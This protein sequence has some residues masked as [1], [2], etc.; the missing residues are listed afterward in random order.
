MR[1]FYTVNFNAR[2]CTMKI[3]V[4]GVPLLNMEVE[5]QCSS[6]YPFNNL[7]LESGWVTIRYEAFPLKGTVQLHDEAYLSGEVEMYDMDSPVEPLSK[8]ASYETPTQEKVVVPYIVHEEVFHVDVPYTLVGWRQSMKLDR[9]EDD[10]RPMVF[11]KYNSIISMMRNRSFAQYEEAF[12]ERENIM[13]VC[14]NISDEEKR[15][16]MKAVEEAIMSCSEIVPLSS[17]D[18]IELAAD[19]RLVR[20]VK[21]DGESALRLKND[22]DG[23]EIMI[24]LWLHMKSGS[25]ELTII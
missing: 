23:E 7:L 22:L 14:F 17:R 2:M 25:K 12:R 5:G 3:S 19:G 9:F 21:G 11:K 15:E 10:L 24:E 6:R 13:A 18:E 4:N 1:P 20:L 8:M 16:R